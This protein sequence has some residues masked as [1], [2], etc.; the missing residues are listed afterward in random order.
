MDHRI[1]Q[2]Y[3]QQYMDRRLKDAARE[4]LIKS[5]KENSE[6]NLAPAGREVRLRLKH[7]LAIAALI[8][9]S[10][11]VWLAQLV[12]AAGGGSGGGRYLVM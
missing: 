6:R 10:L 8:I 2:A 3:M 5:A 4:R 11:A 7:K 9:F 1:K 12:Q